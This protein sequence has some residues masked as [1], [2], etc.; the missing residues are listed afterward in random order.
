MQNLIGLYWNSSFVSDMVGV[1]IQTS[2]PHARESN[3]IQPVN[4]FILMI[5]YVI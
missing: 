2:E 3:K 4:F 1:G 5:S